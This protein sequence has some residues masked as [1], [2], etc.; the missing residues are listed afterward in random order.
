LSAPP[1]WLALNRK[2]SPST[3]FFKHLFCFRKDWPSLA[4]LVQE[5]R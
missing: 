3:F 5:T 2:S 1:F 4:Q